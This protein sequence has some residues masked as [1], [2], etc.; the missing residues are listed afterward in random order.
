[1]LRPGRIHICL[2]YTSIPVQ[3][4]NSVPDCDIRVYFQDS[5]PYFNNASRY[6][7]YSSIEEED[8][9]K[10]VYSTYRKN[11]S[12][13]FILSSQE[14][15]GEKSEDTPCLL[16]TSPAAITAA[17]N[18][19]SLFVHLFFIACSFSARFGALPLC[20]TL[21]RPNRHSFYKI[22]LKERIQ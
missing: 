8:W 9:F 21:N 2:L 5:F 14:L 18:T 11:R 12:S 17:R 16:Y 6:F 10:R 20:L 1:M 15:S 13:F 19:D 4:R 3:I 7:T 22:F